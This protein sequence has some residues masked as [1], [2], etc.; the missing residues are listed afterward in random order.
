MIFAL[1]FIAMLGVGFYFYR[2]NDD[3]DDYYVGGRN[4]GSFVTALSAGAW[5]AGVVVR[6]RCALA[7]CERKQVSG[8]PGACSGA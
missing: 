1:Y 4:M 6:G 5:P 3:L 8:S 2:K 7:V